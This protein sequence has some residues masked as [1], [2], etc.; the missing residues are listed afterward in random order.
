M[1]L[2]GLGVLGM[3]NMQTVVAVYPLLL[4]LACWWSDLPTEVD[5]HSRRKVDLQWV[6]SLDHAKTILDSSS[7]SA[8]PPRHHGR[9]DG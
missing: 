9:H 3:V 1:K 7:H 8:L 4:F 2:E 5:M 6:L